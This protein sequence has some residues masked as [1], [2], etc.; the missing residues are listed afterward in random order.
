MIDRHRR[1]LKEALEAKRKT[2][3]DIRKA[4]TAT[5][6]VLKNVSQGDLPASEQELVQAR[7]AIDRALA[8]HKAAKGKLD[9]GV[10]H[11]M[12][13]AGGLV[14]DPVTID[15]VNAATIFVNYD[16]FLNEYKKAW[17][18]VFLEEIDPHDFQVMFLSINQE[19]RQTLLHNFKSLIEYFDADSKRNAS[20]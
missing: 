2:D 4:L 11:L 9:A 12:E 8:I 14:N 1:R 16:V 6:E 17:A 20:S 3:I 13:S 18:K 7:E 10:G 5:I 15:L 19:K